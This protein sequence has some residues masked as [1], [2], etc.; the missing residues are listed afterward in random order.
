M[1]M[2]EM[3]GRTWPEGFEGRGRYDST[4]RAEECDRVACK[5]TR[6]CVQ[7]FHEVFRNFVFLGL[8]RNSILRLLW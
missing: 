4:L 7:G 8:V 1:C 3:L 5:L 6:V 2:K